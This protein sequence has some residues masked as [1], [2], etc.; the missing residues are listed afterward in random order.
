MLM[1]LFNIHG[2]ICGTAPSTASQWRKNGNKAEIEK[3]RIL[4]TKIYEMSSNARQLSAHFIKET[5]I[6]LWCRCYCFSAILASFPVWYILYSLWVLC[7][8]CVLCYVLVTIILVF[9]AQFCSFFIFCSILSSHRL[10]VFP[11]AHKFTCFALKGAQIKNISI[12]V[13][14]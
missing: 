3:K 7:A 10:Y 8:L 14:K 13:L 5:L 1:I 9:L 11:H 12:V 6:W 4:K 2:P